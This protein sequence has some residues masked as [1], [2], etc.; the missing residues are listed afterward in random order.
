MYFGKVVAR[1]GDVAFMQVFTL[2]AKRRA[3]RLAWAVQLC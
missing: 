3:G 2:E 1:S